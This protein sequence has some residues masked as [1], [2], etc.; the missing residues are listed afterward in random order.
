MKKNEGRKS[1]DTVPLLGYHAGGR[2]GCPYIDYP[3]VCR[4][5]CLPWRTTSPFI[6]SKTLFTSIFA[7]PSGTHAR[8]GPNKSAKPIPVVAVRAYNISLR[9]LQKLAVHGN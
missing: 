9:T 8:G 5:G 3:A 1:R 2:R 6:L 7:S 4:I